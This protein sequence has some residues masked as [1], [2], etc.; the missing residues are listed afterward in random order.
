MSNMSTTWLLLILFY[1][2]LSTKG[3]VVDIALC[4]KI[5]LTA[6]ESVNDYNCS[7]VCSEWLGEVLWEWFQ[8]R[9]RTELADLE[10]TVWLCCW[11]HWSVDV[12]R[13]TRPEIDVQC[14]G[15]GYQLADNLLPGW[16]RHI[17][18]DDMQQT[19]LYRLVYFRNFVGVVDCLVIV[20]SEHS[21]LHSLLIDVE[22]VSEYVWL[23]VS[24][25]L[26]VSVC[27]WSSLPPGSI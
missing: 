2:L 4:Q 17:V 6:K 13:T 25:S 21:L 16:W 9:W 5:G 27:N 3:H 1:Y 19:V 8:T 22:S 23:Y 15:H 18:M 12:G 7:S 26:S 24:L 14:V 20:E 10:D 11:R